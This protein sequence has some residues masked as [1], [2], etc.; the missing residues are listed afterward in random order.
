M[1]IL[2]YGRSTEHR[3]PCYPSYCKFWLQIIYS[4]VYFLK[5]FLPISKYSVLW[6]FPS[7]SFLFLYLSSKWIMSSKDRYTLSSFV[8]KSYIIFSWRRWYFKVL[9]DK[10]IISI[11]SKCSHVC[12]LCRQL[13]CLWMRHRHLH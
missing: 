12:C 3:K 6:W 8:M 7:M 9:E 5:E 2:T 11:S 4:Q 10:D 13:G 1:H